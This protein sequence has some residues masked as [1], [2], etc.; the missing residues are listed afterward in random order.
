MKVKVTKSCI[1]N[2]VRKDSHHCMI[3]DAIHQAD[4]EA[5]YV[6]VDLQSIRWTNLRTRK[7]YFCLTPTL[8]QC[9]LLKF[10]MGKDVQPFGFTVH[11][12]FTRKVG[13]HGSPEKLKAIKKRFADGTAKKQPRKYRRPVQQ[14]QFGL[15]VLIGK[16]TT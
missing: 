12:Q 5:K 11:P 1:N 9:R 2:A 8:A 6:L 15:R 4:P 13:W 10:D 14:R 16:A 7:R 3:A